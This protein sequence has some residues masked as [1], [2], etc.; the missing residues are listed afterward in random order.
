MADRNSNDNNTHETVTAIINILSILIWFYWSWQVWFGNQK[1]DRT[2]WCTVHVI[3]ALG[4]WF[5]YVKFGK[6]LCWY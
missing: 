6:A 2:L 3:T 5:I 4:F 1:Q